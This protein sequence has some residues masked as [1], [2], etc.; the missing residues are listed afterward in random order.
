MLKAD[1]AAGR[2][3]AVDD[4]FKMFADGLFHYALTLTRREATA[5]EV[6]QEVFLELISR[7]ERLREVRD[8]KGYL[9]RAVR[10]RAFNQIRR[11]GREQPLLFELPASGDETPE[12]TLALAEGIEE[13]LPEQREVL[14]LKIYQGLTFREIAALLDISPNTAA[15]RYRYALKHLKEWMKSGHR[16]QEIG[17]APA[18]PGTPAG[19]SGVARGAAP[20][21]EG[22]VGTPP[23][24]LDPPTAG[25]GERRADDVAVPGPAGPSTRAASYGGRSTGNFDARGT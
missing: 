15:S 23:D 18:A 9:L 16:E 2:P 21:R 17:R 24:G 13:L 22:P 1:L 8:L 12:E 20:V 19:T 10:N 4:L 14:V 5:E 7:P 3:E 6:V 25:T 11:D